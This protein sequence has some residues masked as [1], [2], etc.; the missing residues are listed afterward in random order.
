M[1]DFCSYES[2]GER[3]GAYK[4]QA[5]GEID[6]QKPHTGRIKVKKLFQLKLK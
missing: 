1:D 6:Q 4:L 5:K 3:A 2:Q